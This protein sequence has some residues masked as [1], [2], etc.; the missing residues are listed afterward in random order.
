[1]EEKRYPVSV[2]LLGVMH[3]ETSKLYMTSVLWSDQSEV[4]VYRKL[5]DFKTLHK[6]LK[7]KYL[8][9]NPFKNSERILPKFKADRG[10]AS[11]QAKLL[12]RSV[13][14]LKSLEAY[15]AE[16]LSSHERISKGAEL[17]QFLLPRADDLKPEFARNSV[18]IMPSEDPLNRTDLRRSDMGVTQPFVTETYRCIAPYE[19]K[20]TKNRPFKVDMDELVDVLIKDKGGWWLVEN[21]AKCI[22]WFPAPYLEKADVD[23]EDN[24]RADSESDLYVVTRNYKSMNPDELSVQIGSVV[25]VLQKS[26]NGWWFIRYNHK[27]GYIPS[28]YLQPYSNPRVRMIPGQLEIHGSSLFLAQPQIAGHELNLSQTNLQLPTAALRPAD[29]AKSR[30]VEMLHMARPGPTAQWALPTIEVQLSDQGRSRSLTGSSENSETSFS[31]DSSSACSNSFNGGV[32]DVHRSVTP[33]PVSSKCLSPDS[34]AEG[35]LMASTSDP[36]LF[37]FSRM[38]KVP[39]RPQAQEIL[40]R[41]TTVTRKNASKNQLSL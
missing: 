37:K 39:P 19:T 23:G 38:P 30:S 28:M 8:S 26:N 24:D 6:Q 25:E 10:R 4:I 35:R 33:T 18:I 36:G 3:K 12:N 21:E 29:K 34:D 9:S 31:D 5:E 13:L 27:V 41:C 15:C 2:R 17:T 11:G 7:K 20:D 1:M 22:A 14:R 16:L 40:Q 32:P